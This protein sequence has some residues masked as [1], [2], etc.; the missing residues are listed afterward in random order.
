MTVASPCTKICRL[1]EETGLC[2]GCLRSREEIRAWAKAGDDEKRAI[3]S[4]LAG[5]QS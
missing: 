5:R 3:L 4:R 2:R 1:D